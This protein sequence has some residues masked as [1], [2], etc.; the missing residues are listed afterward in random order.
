[1][2]TPQ[3]TKILALPACGLMLLAGS[4]SAQVIADVTFGSNNDGLGG[5]TQSTVDGVETTWTTN[6]DN[7]Q[8]R[9]EAT[10]TLNSTLL[11]QYA[12]SRVAG[13]AYNVQ[14]TVLMSDG[15]ADDNNRLGFMLFGVDSEELDAD[16]TDIIGFIFNTDDSSSAGPPGNNAD[17]NIRLFQGYNS[18]SLDVTNS[19]SV[20]RDQTNV[21]YAQ[22]L[23]GTSVTFSVDFSFDSRL[24]DHDGDGGAGTPDQISLV[25]DITGSLIQADGN[26]TSTGT[27][28]VL[29][30][31]YTGEYFGFVNRAR[32]RN[33]L[34]D[35]TPTAEER[36]LPW[37]MQ[38]ES[39]YLEQIAIPE[40]STTALLFGLASCLLVVRRKRS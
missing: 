20:L 9:S 29:A 32:A 28:S 1:M 12:I 33:F 14:G 23:F 19:P 10:G 7:V 6:T 5:F 24:F 34:T 16:A 2:K 26:I 25:L 30:S 36:S 18:A 40:P 13:A 35:A 4:A 37:E 3:Y 21:P 8:Y 11:G 38:Y 27:A 39:F 31:N 22:D 17:D 15:Y